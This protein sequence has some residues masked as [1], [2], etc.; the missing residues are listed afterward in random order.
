MSSFNKVDFNKNIFWSVFISLFLISVISLSF[1][2]YLFIRTPKIAY[3]YNSRILSEYKGVKESSK[4]YEQKVKAW[5]ANIDTL[6]AGLAHE[7][8]IFKQESSRLPSNER[9]NREDALRK[10]EQ[11][12]LNYKAALE[13]KADEE[14]ELMGASVLNQINSYIL[15]YGKRSGYDYIF[16]VAENGNLLYGREGDDITDEVLKVLNAKYSGK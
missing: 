2:L 11:E 4:A 1:S 16:G 13:E 12:L 6:G 8:K 15:E 14:K 3:V 7:I 5:Q 9:R 10:R